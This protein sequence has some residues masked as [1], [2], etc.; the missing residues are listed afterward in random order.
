MPSYGIVSLGKLSTFKGVSPMRTTDPAP[1]TE[2]QLDVV[3]ETFAGLMILAE[4]A[5]TVEEAA[6]EGDRV[7]IEILRRRA[8]LP[9]RLYEREPIDADTLGVPLW[10]WHAAQL[11]QT[12]DSIVNGARRDHPNWQ[13]RSNELI[14]PQRTKVDYESPTERDRL[15]AYRLRLAGTAR[16]ASCGAELTQAWDWRYQLVRAVEHVA[17]HSGKFL[18]RVPNL[19]TYWG[20]RGGAVRDHRCR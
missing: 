7:A 14:P 10:Q 16:C 9:F 8:G 5:R 20:P 11:E 6:D 19:L 3:R 2:A 12:P 15:I 1:L 4:T 18:M 13:V 17:D